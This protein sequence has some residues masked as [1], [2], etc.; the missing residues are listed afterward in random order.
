MIEIKKYVIRYLK[1]STGDVVQ[2]TEILTQDFKEAMITFYARSIGKDSLIVAD[3]DLFYDA[4]Y[5]MS[6]AAVIN[7]LNI[8]MPSHKII[9]VRFI[10]DQ[11][12]YP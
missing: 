6:E 10:V 7:F 9:A 4:I 11:E 12:V 8:I 5:E 2:Y 3:H 1:E